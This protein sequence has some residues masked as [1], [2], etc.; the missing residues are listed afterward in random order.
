MKILLLSYTFPPTPGIGGR[1]WAKFAKYLTKE[2]VEFHVIYS[3]KSLVHGNFWM[4]DVENNTK[5]RRYPLNFRFNKILANE[6][7]SFL[8]KILYR[9]IMPWAKRSKHNPYDNTAFSENRVVE[10]CKKIIEKEQIDTLVITGAPFNLFYFGALIKQQTGVKLVLDYR[11]LWNGHPTFSVYQKLSQK[12][13]DYGLFQEKIA[14]KEADQILTVNNGLKMDLLELNDNNDPEK[15]HLIYNGFDKDDF[16]TDIPKETSDLITMVFAGNLEINLSDL[17]TDFV[18]AYKNLKVTDAGTYEKFKLILNVKTN[19]PK[20]KS[21]LHKCEDEHFEIHDS[22]L[23]KDEYY[24]S[25]RKADVG[26]FFLSKVYSGAFITKFSDFIVNE[27]FMV[28]VGFEGDC[29][30]YLD[31]N[32]IGMT[33]KPGDGIEF[34]QQLADVNF[35]EAYQ[36][37]D[38]A[39]FNIEKI[40]KKLIE[41]IG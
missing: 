25:L 29:S 38:N 18:T 27:N 3:E 13:L 4:S 36:N 34:F 15:F 20:L 12:Q 17:V 5:I 26:L 35:N 33:F 7:P 23:P 16:Y 32:G 14:L 2:N 41:I 1:R 10:L 28:Q 30:R 37:Y 9:I 22:F 8:Q 24:K 6:N 40:S 21:F 39:D 19:D 31:E 11:D